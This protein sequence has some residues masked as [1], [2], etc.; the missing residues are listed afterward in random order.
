MKIRIVNTKNSEH[1]ESLRW[2]QLKCLPYDEICDVSV[3]YWWI[4]YSAVGDRI[5]FAGLVPSLSFSD[6]GYLCRAG[7]IPA[8]RGQGLQKKLIQARIAKAKK[9]KWNWLVTD[10]TDNMPSSNNL[11]A[12]GF[13]LYKPKNPW[14]FSS[15]LY[16][17]YKV[18]A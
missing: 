11:I 16:W 10:T 14:A 6:C 12:A 17:K 13:R 1:A 2:L 7:I 4:L 15:S 5:G 9:L 18:A 8:F 3:G